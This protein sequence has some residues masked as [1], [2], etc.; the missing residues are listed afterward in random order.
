MNVFLLNIDT[1]TD[2]LDALTKFNKASVVKLN[3]VGPIDNRPS[4][5]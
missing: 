2:W 3:G 1:I 5:D 4:T